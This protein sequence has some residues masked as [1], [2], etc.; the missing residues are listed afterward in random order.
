MANWPT[1]G[2]TVYFGLFYLGGKTAEKSTVFCH[3]TCHDGSDSQIGAE[4]TDN[5]L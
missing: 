1:L 4:N 3:M 5:T 2:G